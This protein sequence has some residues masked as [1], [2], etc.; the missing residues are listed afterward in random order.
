MNQPITLRTR[1]DSVVGGTTPVPITTH[2]TQ[3]GRRPRWLLLH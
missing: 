3:E 1:A 2:H